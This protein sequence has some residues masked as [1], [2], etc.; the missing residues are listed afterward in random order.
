MERVADLYEG[1]GRFGYPDVGH[2]STV[3]S[4]GGAIG[5]A[6][7]TKRF[8]DFRHRITLRSGVAAAGARLS[9]VILRNSPLKRRHFLPAPF[10]HRPA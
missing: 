1:A 3:E 8:A 4:A 6:A 5:I 9:I 10:A 2:A 7:D